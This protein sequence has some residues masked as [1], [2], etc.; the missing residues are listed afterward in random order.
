[1]NKRGSVILK[2]LFSIFFSLYVST[3][4]GVHPKKKTLREPTA[5]IAC[6]WWGDLTNVWTPIGWKNHLFRFDVLYNGTVI[7]HPLEAP[8][9]KVKPHIKPYAGQ[10]VILTF[11]PSPSCYV[12]SVNTRK[13][14][15]R[16]KERY[17]I[18]GPD[19]IPGDQGWNE[20]FAPVLWTRW[21]Q[22]GLVLRKEIFG[23][24]PGAGKVKS[25]VEPLFSWIRLSIQDVDPENI[26]EEYGF[27]IKLS[28]TN[29][30]NGG[31][32]RPL[33][34][35][36]QKI[37]YP[38]KLKADIPEEL[39]GRPCYITEPDGKVRLAIA[40]GQV[41]NVQ[42]FPKTKSDPENLLF[43]AVPVRKGAYVDLLL[44]LLPT[45]RA[46]FERELALGS[47]RALEQSNRY[48][49]KVPTTAS[50]VETPEKLINNAI[51]HNVKLAQI[52]TET[53][54]DTGLSTFLSG[55]F[56][57]AYLW[58][59]PTSMTSYMLLDIMGHHDFVAENLKIFKVTQGT[60][61][62]PG[63]GAHDKKD[64]VNYYRQHPGYLSAPKSLSLID[65]TTDHGSILH[66]VCYHALLTDDKDFINYWLEP[67]L[68]A[69]DF[70]CDA[71]AI[72]GHGGIEGLMPM[73]VDTDNQKQSQS[74][75]ADG[76]NYLG[77]STS[78]RLLRRLNHPRAE[79]FAQEAKNYKQLFVK[80]IRE[81]T[82]KNPVWTD[83]QGREHHY[84]PYGF[85]GWVPGFDE[86]V[87]L[88]TGPLFLVFVGLLDADDPL[89]RS[90]CELFR[91]RPDL[92][93]GKRPRKTFGHAPCLV[94]EISTCEPDYSW[95]IF[96]THQLGD[97]HK[98]LEGMYS[99][100]AGGMSRQTFVSCESR[101][102]VTGNVFVGPIA[103]YLTRLAVIDDHLKPDKEL[104]LLRLCP[105]AWLRTDRE[106]VFENMPTTFGPVTLKFQ[107]LSGSANSGSSDK[108][109]TGKWLRVSFTPKFRYNPGKVIL[110]VPP[111]DGLSGVIVNGREF[112]VKAG[113][114]LEI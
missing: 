94:H 77:L 28:A 70:I 44:P 72:T 25:G 103:T 107:L 2:V 39:S 49:S 96:H 88:D 86:M 79:E 91:Q 33:T 92:E 4:E 63:K 83:R 30:H 14:S 62:S 51:T 50:R 80:T 100:F 42:F 5:N 95:N 111:V 109:K 76:W 99:L 81:Q 98:F 16:G 75:W 82:R 43:V 74:V 48:W 101:G 24:M 56:N 90:T 45:K 11:L 17:S 54:P 1:M 3:V 36:A 113:G 10:G 60:R 15:G 40:P 57:Y 34:Y 47:D 65:W 27:L 32:H 26:F 85:S 6:N 13:I 22:E 7:A 46:E 110:H 19:T 102:G 105:L 31:I 35:D 71:R 61:K 73:G 9:G 59:T 89:M 8:L 23:H 108:R 93:D 66:S 104:H 87:Y 78:V 64:S 84:V 21:R 37:A 114:T 12:G 38:R 55:S 69:C 52:I 20:E 41:S 112:R 53:N 97:R 106:T 67:I 29:I 58:P 18:A 68:K